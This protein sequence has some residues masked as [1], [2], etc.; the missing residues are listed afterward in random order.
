MKCLPCTSSLP[1]S[2]F[3]D[4]FQNYV[5]E[6]SHLR[7]G[8]LQFFPASC[9]R[10]FPKVAWLGDCFELLPLNVLCCNKVLKEDVFQE[11]HI[12]GSHKIKWLYCFSHQFLSIVF[13]LKTI[14]P[15]RTE[16]V[17]QDNL[18]TEL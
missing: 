8:H 5:W 1:V 7:A 15:Q 17:F 6:S 9:R 3:P 14:Q 18:R 11:V 13:I 12:T 16:D 4:T 10:E 2:F